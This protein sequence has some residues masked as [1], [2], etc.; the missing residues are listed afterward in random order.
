MK[1]RRGWRRTCG[2]E[3]IVPGFVFLN[4]ILQFTE[5]EEPQKILQVLQ[6]DES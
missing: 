2:R 5:R 1:K 6:V 3:E 4:S